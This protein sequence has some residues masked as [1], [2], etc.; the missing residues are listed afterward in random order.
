MEQVGFPFDIAIVDRRLEPSQMCSMHNK[1]V[2]RF[3]RIGNVEI[4]LCDDCL[5]S[6][7]A[8]IDAEASVVKRKLEGEEGD[9]IKE[10][11]EKNFPRHCVDIWL[12]PT[13]CRTKFVRLYDIPDE[14][15]TVTRDKVRD[16][17]RSL[18]RLGKIT[19]MMYTPSVVSHSNTI[20]YYSTMVRKG[21]E[22]D[23]S[24]VAVA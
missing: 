9:I 15:V 3:L 21:D 8:C 1:P 10:A 17:M 13:D 23:G 11:L 22:T 24:E 19:D 14:V 5:M 6:A 18:E 2:R 7:K 20:K 12:D 16:I 4:A